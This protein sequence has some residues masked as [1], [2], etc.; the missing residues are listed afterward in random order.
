MSEIAIRLRKVLLSVVMTR[1]SFGIGSV[2]LNLAISAP[3]LGDDSRRGDEPGH[4]RDEMM[5]G[6][7]RVEAG[8][9]GLILA[10]KYLAEEGYLPSQIVPIKYF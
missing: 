2:S 8:Y 5:G 3:P 10:P 4:L 9:S 7:A 6:R 1:S